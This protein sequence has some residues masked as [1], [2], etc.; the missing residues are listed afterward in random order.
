MPNAYNLSNNIRKTT[1]PLSDFNIRK[2][3]LT[4]FTPY[5]KG[6]AFLVY[7]VQVEGTPNAGSEKEFLL[8][9]RWG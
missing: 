6:P 1:H 4:S 3:L 5:L 9:F 8:F 2:N 7:T